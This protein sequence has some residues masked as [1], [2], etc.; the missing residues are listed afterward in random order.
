MSIRGAQLRRMPVSALATALVAC[1]GD[2]STPS[3]LAPHDDAGGDVVDAA[4]ERD[5]RPD[6]AEAG[7]CL[8]TS[9]DPDNCGTCGHSCGGGACIGGV[10]QPLAGCG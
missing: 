6:V 4:V 7:A 1:G 3:G 5:G 9:T 10:C 2:V 8:D